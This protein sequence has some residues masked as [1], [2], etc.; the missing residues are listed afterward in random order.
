MAHGFY[1]WSE[2][3]HCRWSPYRPGVL[4]IHLN[5]AEERVAAV[6]KP[7]AGNLKVLPMTYFYRVPERHR[8]AVE[9]AIRACGKWTD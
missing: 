1:S 9:A 7:V 4:D 6:F 2:V 8:A 3:S 5:A